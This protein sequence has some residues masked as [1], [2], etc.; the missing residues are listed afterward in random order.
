ML[1][2]LRQFFVR[3]IHEAPDLIDAFF[4]KAKKL[5]KWEKKN[6]MTS[7]LLS[8]DPWILCQWLHIS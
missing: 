2:I 4:L 3:E 8:N 5:V 7:F 6:C 1:K